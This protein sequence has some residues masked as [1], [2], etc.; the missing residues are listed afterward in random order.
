M[1]RDQYAKL[2]IHDHHVIPVPD[3]SIFVT[4]KGNGIRRM[5]LFKCP[6]GCGE[7]MWLPERISGDTGS[8][9]PTWEFHISDGKITLVPSVV[10]LMGCRSHYFIRE[11]K[12]IWCN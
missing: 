11:N 4:D 8:G 1:R 7:T 3:D 10:M 12:V 5:I 2:E 6:C 9:W